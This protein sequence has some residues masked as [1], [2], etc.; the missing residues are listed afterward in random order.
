MTRPLTEINWQA[1]KAKF[2]GKEKEVFENL[3]YLLFC[4]Q[5]GKILGFLDIKIKSD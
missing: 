3:S 5:I 2:N 4:D 1:F